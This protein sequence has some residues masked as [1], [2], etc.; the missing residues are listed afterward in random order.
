M[1]LVKWARWFWRDDK[2]DNK[3][4]GLQKERN[5]ERP[6]IISGRTEMAELN[7][8]V[9]LPHMLFGIMGSKYV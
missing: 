2:A 9:V 5:I 7:T 6:R 1:Q 8:F 4:P 3:A